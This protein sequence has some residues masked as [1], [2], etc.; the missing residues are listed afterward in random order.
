M[1]QDSIAVPS[2]GVRR[3]GVALAS[4]AVLG[5]AVSSFVG[6]SII[7]WWYEPPIKDA[8]SCASSVRGALGQFVTM[9]LVCAAVGAVMI[10]VIA[11][12]VARSRRKPLSP[13]I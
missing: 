8:F 12:F 5:F 7:G 9:Q 11:F 4:G 6:P 3:V 10:A 13:S 1:T 2:T